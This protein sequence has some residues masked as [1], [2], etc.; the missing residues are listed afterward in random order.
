MKW[1]IVCILLMCLHTTHADPFY[2]RFHVRP[3]QNWINDPNGPFRDATTGLLHLWMQYNPYGAVWGNMS[4]Y[5]MV[6]SDYVSWE[7]I[8]VSLTNNDTYD[9]AGVFSG[10]ISVDTESNVPVLWYTCVGASQQQCCAVPAAGA[11][12]VDKDPKLVDWLKCQDNPVIPNFPHQRDGDSFRDPTTMWQ[13]AKGQ[14]VLLIGGSIP[15]STTPQRDEAVA[16][17]FLS[18]DATLTRNFTFSNFLLQ[19]R[20]TLDGMF[21]CPDLFPFGKNTSSFYLLKDSSGGRDEYRLGYLNQ[22]VG[23]EIFS[24]ANSELGAFFS[25]YIDWGHYYASKSFLDSVN[26][27]RVI[28]GWVSEEDSD[29]EKRGWQGLQS[30]PRKMYLLQDEATKVM[31]LN[32]EPVEEMVKLRGAV[33]YQLPQ[34]TVLNDPSSCLTLVGP[35]GSG[36]DVNNS[37][38]QQE[39]VVDLSF[40][41]TA[42]FS[43]MQAVGVHVRETAGQQATT[44]IRLTADPQ[45]AAPRDATDLSGADYKDFASDATMAVNVQV[46]QCADECQNDGRCLSW[47]YIREGFNGTVPPFNYS[48]RCSL[49]NSVPSATESDCCV[50]GRTPSIV[51]S[52]DRSLSGTSGSASTV[53]ARSPV[54]AVSGT[55]SVSMSIF[56]DHSVLEVFLHKGASSITSR[57]Y[58]P[59][60]ASAGVRICGSDLGPVTVLNATIWVVKS[61]F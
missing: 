35:A 6:S 54:V 4:W 53:Y 49:K 47:T 44:F 14:N 38:L 50:S 39:I 56:V 13:N 26:E 19:D 60:P 16:V 32:I 27:R 25:G 18:D 24:P 2:P 36:V 15:S 51:L 40:P 12:Y 34:E 45:G 5:H 57:L 61:M 58:N 48:P 37:Q 10:S 21:E 17:L 30:L 28:W 55:V 9:S 33:V 41:E 59:I 20:F 3:P 52:V 29:G 23:Q 22:S 1:M 8:G 46:Q 42:L 11:Q 31:R 7:M 43:V